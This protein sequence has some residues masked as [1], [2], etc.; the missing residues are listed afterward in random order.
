MLSCLSLALISGQETEILLLVT[1][2]GGHPKT[3]SIGR[4][5]R[6]L[7][8]NCSISPLATVA[9]IWALCAPMPNRNTETE[10]WRRKKEW[11][12]YFAK[13]RENNRLAPRKLT[14]PPWWVGKGYIVRQKYMENFGH[15][16]NSLVFFLLQFQKG[17]V[18]RQ[19][20]GVCRVLGGLSSI[21]DESRPQAVSLLLLLWLAT[22]L[23]FFSFFFVKFFFL[24]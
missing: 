19:D 20:W 12:Y 2:G 6:E 22:V 18:C 13:Q 4:A 1:V 17:W 24:L 3:P 14:S 16:S 15:G 5:L 8:V 10:L 11:L 9:K 7:T 23:L 21:L